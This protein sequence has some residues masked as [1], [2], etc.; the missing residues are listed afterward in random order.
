MWDNS[1]TFDTQVIYAMRMVQLGFATVEQAA[2][3]CGMEPAALRARLASGSPA[4][5]QAME[6]EKFFAR[7]DR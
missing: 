3:T 6:R 7:F 1:N 5:A 4:S 2:A